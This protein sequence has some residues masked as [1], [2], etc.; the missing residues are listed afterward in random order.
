MLISCL[1]ERK[2]SFIGVTESSDEFC[3]LASEKQTKLKNKIL[4]NEDEFDSVKFN[5]VCVCVHLS[6]YYQISH[7]LLDRS[8]Y[9]LYH[10]FWIQSDQDGHQ[11]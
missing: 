11:N 6:V 10:N 3:S 7:E 8:Y 4:I 2:L 5:S 9:V 1:S